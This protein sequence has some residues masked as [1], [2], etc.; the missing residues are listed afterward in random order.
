L[1]IYGSGSHKKPLRRENVPK[2]KGVGL[3]ECDDPGDHVVIPLTD[4]GFVICDARTIFNISN[5]GVFILGFANK[6]EA[7]EWGGYKDFE[8]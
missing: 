5:G 3:L 7:R 2:D 8:D 1:A 4:G 6:D